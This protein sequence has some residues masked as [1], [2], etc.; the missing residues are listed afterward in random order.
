MT[1]PGG[2]R[3]RASAGLHENHP[4]P[5]HELSGCARLL[6]ERLRQL[7]HS[8]I[9]EQPG[10]EQRGS[11]GLQLRH[12]DV[13]AA[14]LD[15]GRLGRFDLV[16]VEA[17]PDQQDRRPPRPVGPAASPGELSAQALPTPQRRRRGPRC[18]LV[19]IL[20]L[21]DQLVA[22]RER[23][24]QR[25]PCGVEIGTDGEHVDRIEEV[26]GQRW[27][28]DATASI[29]WDALQLDVLP[30]PGGSDGVARPHIS[31]GGVEGQ[32][33]TGGSHELG[34]QEGHGHRTRSRRNASLPLVDPAPEQHPEAVGPKGLDEQPAF[35]PAQ[36]E[37]RHPWRFVCPHCEQCPGGHSNVA[38]TPANSSGGRLALTGRTRTCAWRVRTKTVKCFK[39][40]VTRV[41]DATGP[42]VAMALAIAPDVDAPQRRSGPLHP[43]AD[44]T[45]SV[46]IC[47]YTEDRWDDLR[48]AIASVLAQRLPA[49]EVLVVI[50]HC[51]PLLRRARA[52]LLGVRVLDNS[53]PSGLSGARN[54]GVAAA[55]GDVVAFLDDDAAAG[56]GWL[57]ALVA[58]YRDPQ[59]IAAG[60]AIHPRWETGR[61]SWFPSEFDWV[62]G[63]TYRGLPTDTS[64][65]RNLIGAN[66]SFRREVFEAV[67]GF[68][69]GL[70]RVGSTPLGCEE[71]EL[72]LR[73][74]AAFPDGILLYEPEAPVWHR[75]PRSR[76][77]WSYFLRRC[78]AEGRSKAVVAH[79][80]GS[81]PAL[82]SERRYVRSVLPRGFGRA[83]VDSTTSPG[84]IRAALAIVLGVLF[85]TYGFLTG[86]L[87]SP[88]G[89][90]SVES[91]QRAAP[92]V[93]RRV[94]D[95]SD[96]VP[97]LRRRTTGT[98]VA[99]VVATALWAWSLPQTDVAAMTDFG[100]L[101][102]LPLTY[103]A[104][105]A[106]LSASFVLHVSRG[107][108]RRV[109]IAHVLLL[110][111]MLHA[112]PT[113][114]Y[115]ALRYA[116]AWKHVG[117]V[118]YILRNHNPYIGNG[119]SAY[120]G[121]PGF[122]TLNATL[123]GGSGLHSALAYASW[124]PMV[125]NL[126]DLVPIVVILRTFTSD[127]RHI[128][129]AIWLYELAN[130]VGQDYFSPQAAAYFLYL[131]VIACCLRWLEDPRRGRHPLDGRARN[132]T[133]MP[134]SDVPRR[135]LAYAVIALLIVALVTSHQLT[136]YV[137]VAAL[138]G[139]ALTRVRRTAWLAAATFV[140]SVVWAAT[141]ARTFFRENPALAFGS[142]G[143]FG[144]NL[145]TTLTNLAPHPS[146]AQIL[147]SRAD[148]L[149]F[150]LVWSLAAWG[151]W[152]QRE[153]WREN[154]P[155]LVLAV[156]PLPMMAANSYGG[157]MLLRVYLFGLVPVCFFA[158]AAFFP[159][160]DA[161][162]SP[163]TA[164]ALLVVTA[165]FVAGFVAGNYG[166]ERANHFTGAEV[167]ASQWLF[168]QPAG[169]VYGVTA[170]F[171]WAFKNYEDYRY[172]WFEYDG[173]TGKKTLLA[174]PAGVIAR[175]AQQ[176]SGGRAYV[177]LGR[178]QDADVEMTG[179]MPPGTLD[180]IRRSLAS[181]PQFTETFRNSDVVIFTY[182]GG[183]ST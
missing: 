56:I 159:R 4:R 121:W 8:G 13:A 140:F 115:T 166:K 30:L 23:C 28:P 35:G 10:V 146:H 170:N 101:S 46:V 155:L 47:A 32:Y 38:A 136:P 24:C 130:W 73:A 178:S 102:V 66:M 11:G 60:G 93:G 118:D 84:R 26:A 157:E 71:T 154:L 95:V 164:P 156:T 165:L 172:H 44:L 88:A 68:S 126:L 162:R 149:L 59:V 89:E 39:G 54:T 124:G 183:G 82:A 148:R 86:P 150:L 50:D 34:E 53:G 25:F 158:A 105:L 111:L 17:V 153:R 61:P 129:T 18:A 167:A 79:L 85:T 182:T 116:W 2:A 143:L 19:E 160:H 112:T 132:V 128:W 75:V 6:D 173:V 138:I 1:G 92:T 117:V 3:D 27:D 145:V 171:P 83:L 67:G 152:R 91:P 80:A 90:T 139:L 120:A 99:L 16:D 5:E 70:G 96:P 41:P 87:T 98:V 7:V 31:F 69:Q 177:V 104:G 15:E 9:A 64:P 51:P 161:G 169:T 135:T 20:L 137:L 37:R 40:A 62:I 108:S 36:P 122:F 52:E 49:H 22:E 110:V 175:E 144:S 179:V 12:G 76:A 168:S 78:L 81:A 174:D 106:V 131:C 33:L 100:L 107:G 58:P 103:W 134:R 94:T 55:T 21:H 163:R 151:L 123:T 29:E 133:S 181:S 65:V 74:S 176:Q 113:L 109:A 77:T 63:C 45:A 141:A 72:C 180:R 125:F 57:E 114:I 14:S 119:F 97:S 147:L 42:L 127:R 142:I 43:V 48:R